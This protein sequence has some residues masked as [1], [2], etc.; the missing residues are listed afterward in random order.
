MNAGRHHD[1]RGDAAERYGKHSEANARGWAV[2]E[3]LKHAIRQGEAIR[4]AWPDG[5]AN[6]SADRSHDFPTAVLPAFQHDGEPEAE[7]TGP[8]TATR[9]ARKWF[10]PGGW[11]GGQCRWQDAVPQVRYQRD[12]AA[13][14]PNRRY[15]CML[16]SASLNE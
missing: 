8:T 1:A 15:P 9:D 12:Q 13:M 2:R 5:E 14:L 10:E 16:I 6:A 3:L 7:G 11:S 4:L